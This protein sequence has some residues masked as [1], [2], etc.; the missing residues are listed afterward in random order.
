MV[1][2]VETEIII[3]G[4]SSVSEFKSNRP[5]YS[6]HRGGSAD[7]PEHSLRAYT[8]AALEG[9]GCLEVSIQRTSDGVFV[10]NHDPSINAVV[11]G[12]LSGLPDISAMT[13]A[14]LS[15]YM[16]KAPSGHL[17]RDPEPFIRLTD[18]LDV[19]GDSHVFMVDPKDISTTYYADILDL[20]D[21]RGG[22]QRFIGKWV[23]S[24]I[25]WSNALAARSYESWGAFYGSNWTTGGTGFDP[26]WAAQWTMLGLNYDADQAHWNEILT[27]A[28]SKPVLAHVCPD[29][30]A[31]DMGASKGAVGFQVS[32]IDSV[33]PLF[34]VEEP[35]A[36]APLTYAD[37]PSGMIVTA[38]HDGTN[39]PARP[40][41]RTDLVVEW[42]GPDTVPPGMLTTDI[43]L[44]VAA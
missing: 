2:A 40:T 13:W 42:V 16:I 27:A 28:G 18:L 10:C 43:R 34:V 14:Q 6:A 35:A 37:L 20:L 11:W 5:M 17:E 22:N 7:W 36:D 24:N 38:T 23:G 4:P 1:N 33:S 44:V 21:S 19:Y 12:G 41:S 8:Q 31:V 30:A 3:P 15:T 29:Q 26:A 32:G 39:W 25:T 9:Y